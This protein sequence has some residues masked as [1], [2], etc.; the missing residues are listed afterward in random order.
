MILFFLIYFQLFSYPL[1]HNISSS[2]VTTFLG[3]PFSHITNNI[4]FQGTPVSITYPS[5]HPP[6]QE[7]EDTEGIVNYRRKT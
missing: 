6:V 3:I 1:I 4:T 5:L 2:V 7:D